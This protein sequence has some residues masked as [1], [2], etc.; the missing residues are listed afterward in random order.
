MNKKKRDKK[1]LIVETEAIIAIEIKMRLESKGFEAAFVSTAQKA[2]KL[3][4]GYKP[5]LIL[6]AIILGGGMDGIELASIIRKE[7]NIPVIYLTALD[8]MKSDPRLLETQ[9]VGILGKPFSEN[10]LFEMINTALSN[11]HNTTNNF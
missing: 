3:M 11:I 4:T 9:P 2:L 8:Y 5:D 10:D 7:K 6:T 1:I